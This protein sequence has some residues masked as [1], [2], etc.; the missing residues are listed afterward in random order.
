MKINKDLLSVLIF[1]SLSDTKSIVFLNRKM[2]VFKFHEPTLRGKELSQIAVSLDLRHGSPRNLI[3]IG[4][5]IT[6]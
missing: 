6:F 2:I 5:A 1:D 4:K 3:C